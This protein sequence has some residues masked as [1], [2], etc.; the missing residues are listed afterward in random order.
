[1]LSIGF[2][3]HQSGIIYAGTFQHGI[4]VSRDG[5]VNWKQINVGLLDIDIQSIVVDPYQQDHVLI[6]TGSRLHVSND[7]GESWQ[8][9]Q[10]DVRARVLLADPDSRGLIYAGTYNAGVLVSRDGGATYDPLGEGLNNAEVYSLT[11][12]TADKSLLAGTSLGAFRLAPNATKWQDLSYGQPAGSLTQV[13]RLPGSGANLLAVSGTGLYVS[14]DD[15]AGKPYWFR[16]ADTESRLALPMPGTGFVLLA[17]VHG[18]IFGT[19]DGGRTLVNRSNGL[20]N[21]FVGSLAIL[22]SGGS[23]T[24]L[25]GTDLGVYQSKDGGDQW[26]ASPGFRQTVFELQPDPKRP[27]SV[28]AGTELNG[29]FHSDDSGATW[30]ATGDGVVPA[31][32]YAIAQSPID[33][34]PL[35]AATSGG[36]YRS[37]DNGGHWT[38]ISPLGNAR[39]LVLDSSN[40]PNFVVGADQGQFYIF[41]GAAGTPRQLVRNGI[42]RVDIVSV[43]VAVGDKYYAVLKDGT[44]YAV[45]IR[46][47]DWFRIADTIPDSFNWVTVDPAHTNIVLLGT[48]GGG[49]YRST[50]FGATWQPAR[51]GLSASFVFEITA[52]P[53]TENTFYAATEQGVF[54]SSDGGTTWGLAGQNLPAGL[55]LHLAVQGGRAGGLFASVLDHG[56]FR[57]ASLSSN[58]EPAAS[59]LPGDAA[60]V[61]GYNP[62]AGSVAYAGTLRRGIFRT[63]DAGVSWSSASHGMSLFVRGIAIDPNHAGVLSA[64]TLSAGI[65][66]STDYGASW[67]PS[68]LQDRTLYRLSYNHGASA[69]YAATALGVSRS[70]DQ[71]VT[72]EHLGQQTPF[73][74]SLASHPGRPGVIY[75]GTFAGQVYR[76]SDG[77]QTWNLCGP[78]LPQADIVHLAVDPQTGAVYAAASL[79]GIYKSTD[80]GATW[81]DTA[82]IDGFTRD[83]SITSLCVDRDGTVL[84]A[85]SPVGAF[86]SLDGGAS[87]SASLDGLTSLEVTSLSCGAPGN[88]NLAAGTLAQGVFLSTDRG[89]SWTPTT[90]IGAGRI[91]ALAQD[92]ANPSLLY[93]GTEKGLFLSRDTGTTWVKAN[94]IPDAEVADIKL[95]AR[96][97]LAAVR[98]ASVFKSEDQG[99]TWSS[100]SVASQGALFTAMALDDS[101]A[102]VGT[103]SEGVS[104]STDG[105]ATWTP[106]ASPGTVKPITL[107]LATHPRDENTIYAGTAGLGVI[108]STDGGTNWRAMN[109]G[110][111]HLF[112]LTLTTDPQE[113][114]TVLAGTNLGG[115]YISRDGGN[116]WQQYVAGMFHRNVTSLAVDPHNHKVIYAGCEGGGVFRM[117]LP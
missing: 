102:Y 78:G 41:E 26:T 89:R 70:R 72:W 23:S 46:D 95:D 24:V 25:A 112:V 93:A 65:F 45:S 35:Y 77:G 1:M 4:Y 108:K 61:L 110:L 100:T 17:G 8:Q 64:A 106:P 13:V 28:Y 60:P 51:E 84:T 39:T 43:A 57:L 55:V 67:Q 101:G 20:Q 36:V 56:V 91:S 18:E 59:G 50:D 103:Q 63:D 66:R 47:G 54:Y 16:I 74:F 30:E 69:L 12:D 111:N 116:T 105:G 7:G 82:T 71:G 96:R 33:P 52:D 97:V 3:P 31:E 32:I 15:D 49:I 90:T 114:E 75:L 40:P 58:W 83:S 99:S 48:A 85:G 109:N 113:P 34:F 2:D 73:V 5:G 9:T 22:D 42:P 6:A 86:R 104:K 81:Q 88:P 94:G 14:A 10:Q 107:T 19:F 98:G 44:V 21:S 38:Q 11:F 80:D 27:G 117:V 68:G 79:H 76:T 92:P 53:A 62:A 87:W 115:V 37:F 29:V